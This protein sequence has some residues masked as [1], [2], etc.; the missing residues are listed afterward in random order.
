MNNLGAR[1]Y[2]VAAIMM[3]IAGILWHD[4]ATGWIPAPADLPGRA[5]L[6]YAVGA[7]LVAGGVLINVPRFVAWGAGI[8][9]AV[10]AAGLVLLDLTRL[11]MHVS[12]FDYW[13]SS[14]EQVAITVGGLIA[15]AATVNGPN[16][17]RIEWAGRFAFGLCLLIF[18]AAHFVFAKFSATFVP[19]Y[20]PPSQ[21]FWVYAT[22]VAQIAA[23]VAILSN[24]LPLLGV[25]LLV[26]MYILFGI[27]VHTPRVLAGAADHGNWVEFIVNLALVGV[28]WIMADSLA[29]RRA[30]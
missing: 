24:I 9:T 22:G 19:S 20:I 28:A 2:G 6:A 29:R 11:A 23:G 10:F 3:G 1:V 8:L 7:A 17:A 27:L 15:L 21:M 18:G 14:A 26:V 5:M 25:R 12:G 30:P 4:F 13:E 16:G